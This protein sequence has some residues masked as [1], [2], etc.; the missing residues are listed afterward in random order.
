MIDSHTPLCGQGDIAVWGRGRRLS[1]DRRTF[2]H[3]YSRSQ[4]PHRKIFGPEEFPG[5]TWGLFHGGAE[6]N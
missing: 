3:A 4:F 6:R 1:V 5:E 2:I